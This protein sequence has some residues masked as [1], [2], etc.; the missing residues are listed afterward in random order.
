MN[1]ATRQATATLNKRHAH[2]PTGRKAYPGQ[3]GRKTLQSTTEKSKPQCT[4]IK[5]ASGLRARGQ[6]FEMHLKPQMAAPTGEPS[7]FED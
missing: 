5:H 2:L 3:H 7:F 1:T 4:G 6:Y